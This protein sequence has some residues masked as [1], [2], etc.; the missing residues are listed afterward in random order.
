M[1]DEPIEMNDA[2]IEMNDEAIEIN[3]APIEMNDEAI[4]ISDEAIKINDEAIE[5]SDAPIE[6]NDEAIEIGD[7]PIEVNDEATEITSEPI[8][9][10]E[11]Q[12]RA[13]RLRRARERALVGSLPDRVAVE[14]PVAVA[15][16]SLGPVRWSERRAR[17][18]G[19]R[20]AASR[21]GSALIHHVPAAPE[22][23][24]SARANAAVR[25][26]R[27]R[28]MRVVLVKADVA[29]VACCGAGGPEWGGLAHRCCIARCRRTGCVGRTGGEL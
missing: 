11:R 14:A 15:L 21:K 13:K 7:A 20:H 9:V 10:D 6:M 17:A 25:Q 3:D 12:G 5:I 2:P 26:R 18:R 16:A 4:E 1:N 23:L 19:S 22:A 24:L 28:I 8:D 29:R 27:R